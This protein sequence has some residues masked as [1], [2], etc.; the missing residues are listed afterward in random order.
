MREEVE[1]MVGHIH[2]RFSGQGCLPINYRY[3]SFSHADLVAYYRAS[4]IALVTAL[5][6][7]INLVSE[8]YIAFRFDEMGTVVLSRFV[9]AAR[10]L[11]DAV[12]VKPYDTEDTAEKI[13]EAITMPP[14]EKRRR[15]RRMREIVRR[16]DIYWWL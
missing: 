10:E 3:E 8:E 12:S 7:G 4:G 14:E 9:G 13:Y 1:R 6:D 15:M 16:N 2:G 11:T 5:R